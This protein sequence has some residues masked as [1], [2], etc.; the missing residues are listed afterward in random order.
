MTPGPGKLGGQLSL[1]PAWSCCGG[2]FS[3]GSSPECIL[4]KLCDLA[5]K[6]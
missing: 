4:F 2:K 3:S 5:Q 1:L 6:A